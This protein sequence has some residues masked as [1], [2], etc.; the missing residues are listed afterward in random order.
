MVTTN[1][2]N[3]IYYCFN[4]VFLFY[5]FLAIPVV[6]TKK[7]WTKERV[8]GVVYILLWRIRTLYTRNDGEGQ[9]YACNLAAP[10]ILIFC[11]IWEF[12]NILLI[13]IAL[14][15]KKFWL[16]TFQISTVR[17][18]FFTCSKVIMQG[19]FLAVAY[20]LKTSSLWAEFEN[21]NRCIS[22]RLLSKEVKSI[23]FW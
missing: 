11:Y 20:T 14:Q 23:K 1:P 22:V 10:L 21:K 5:S 2:L 19:K 9:I 15:S 3:T 18:F 8:V 6:Q 13:S 16:K 7:F 4:V 17:T 12:R